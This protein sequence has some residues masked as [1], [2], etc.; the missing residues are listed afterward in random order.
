MNKKPINIRLDPDLWKAAKLQALK[1]DK[2]LQEW[3]T[4]AIKE[5][6]KLT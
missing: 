1:E 6:L 2:T 5:K 3:I 4:E